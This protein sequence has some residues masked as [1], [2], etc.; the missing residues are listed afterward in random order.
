MRVCVCVCVGDSVCAF[1]YMLGSVFS[2]SVLVV[3]VCLSLCL[4]F[5]SACCALASNLLHACTDLV[6][7]LV[8]LV[9]MFS[10]LMVSL[11][12]SQAKDPKPKLPS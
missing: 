8:V 6:M 4:C 3:L 9:F 1:V 10:S 2:R 12:I 11:R 7:A 5:T